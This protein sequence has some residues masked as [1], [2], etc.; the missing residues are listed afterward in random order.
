MALVMVF[1]Y[2]VYTL[3]SKITLKQLCYLAYHVL[4]SLIYLYIHTLKDDRIPCINLVSQTEL[5][6]GNFANISS[7]Y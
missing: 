6:L 4:C 5:D 2:Q 7:N 3:E 1:S